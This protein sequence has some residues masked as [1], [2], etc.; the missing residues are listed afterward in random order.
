MRRF[1]AAF[2][3]V[4]TATAAQADTLRVAVSANFRQVA[5]ILATEFE[6]QTGHTVT[7]S[8]GSTGALYNQISYGAPFDV[9]LSADSR[10]PEM[11]AETG[12]VSGKPVTYAFGR[13]VFWQPGSTEVTYKTLSGWNEKLA[14]ANPDT[15]P[16][17]LA[18][19][20]VLENLGLWEKKKSLV[21]Q[22]T[23]IQQA[24]QY[25]ATGNAG[26]GFVALSQ[27]RTDD[28]Q[29]GYLLL[30]DELY[31]PIRQQAV[32]LSGSKNQKLGQDFLD[33]ILA[34]K[35]Q[36]IV[37][38]AGYFPAVDP[39]VAKVSDTEGSHTP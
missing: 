24:W 35:Q 2:I 25:V 9:F 8:S 15:A 3:V 32:V 17:G 22:G 11:L 39:V 37:Q 29:D 7:L 14:M 20:Q 6:E 30:R 13:L 18:A 33:Y 4:F 38:K 31:N 21:V 19:R 16:Y 10:R 12:R 1:L 5:E 26:A 36:I 28:V 23:S 34:K 27:L